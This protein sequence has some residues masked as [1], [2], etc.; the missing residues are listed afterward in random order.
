V[1]A[2]SFFS[3]S[4]LGW[5]LLAPSHLLLW[6]ALATALALLLRRERLGRW[7]AVLTAA[8][9]VVFGVLPLGEWLAQPLEGQYPRPAAPAHVDGVLTLGGGLGDEILLTRRA[10]AT[11]TSEARLV[12][13]Y[14]L[15]RRYPTARIVFSGGWGRTPDA[16]AAAYVFGQMGLDP[17]RLTLESRSRNTFENLAFSKALV[18]PKPGEVWLLATSAL[19]MPRA[20]AVARRVGW[21]LIPWPTDYLTSPKPRRLGPLEYL[22][23]SGHLFELDQAAHEWIGLWAYR[24]NAMAGKTAG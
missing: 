4:K 22:D 8:L 23:I 15:A 14:E 20:M 9:L 2:N 11:A 16:A 6:L 5:S 18:Q 19:Q 1:N 24:A 10:P 21:P 13:T 3:A 12:S 17:A 7:L